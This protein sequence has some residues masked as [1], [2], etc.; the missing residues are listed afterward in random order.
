M[1]PDEEREREGVV[2][3]GFVFQRECMCGG[4]YVRCGGCGHPA[5][6]AQHHG[7]APPPAG[8]PVCGAPWSSATPCTRA[9]FL[10]SRADDAPHPGEAR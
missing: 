3:V 4:H 8:C 2:T 7:D 5:N 10:A 9:E 6:I 1:T